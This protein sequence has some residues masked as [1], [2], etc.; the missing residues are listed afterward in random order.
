[1]SRFI[2]AILLVPF[3]IPV[4]VLARSEM[5]PVETVKSEIPK[6]LDLPAPKPSPP[7]TEAK[8]T[9]KTPEAE[10]KPKKK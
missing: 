4:A 7:K 5:P 8:A 3:A 10:K 2:L 6:T 9:T 1:M